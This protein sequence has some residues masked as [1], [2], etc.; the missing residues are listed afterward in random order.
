MQIEQIG[1]YI[2][3]TAD[4]IYCMYI[5]TEDWDKKFHIISH[6]EGNELELVEGS[7]WNI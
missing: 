1:Y 7:G 3:Q 5:Q 2:Q 6:W 4:M